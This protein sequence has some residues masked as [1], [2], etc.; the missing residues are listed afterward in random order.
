MV[1]KILGL[2]IVWD[3]V[4]EDAL[5]SDCFASFFLGFTIFF[6]GLII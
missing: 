4:A 6:D 5:V 2:V 3:W 1:D